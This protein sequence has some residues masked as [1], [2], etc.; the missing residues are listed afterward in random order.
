M[1]LDNTCFESSISPRPTG[2]TIR[3]VP[4]NLTPQY[5]E[6]EQLLRQARSAQDKVT[7]LE[8]MLRIIPKHK[9]TEKLQADLKKRLSKLTKKK[10]LP[11]LEVFIAPF[12]RSIE[13]EPAESS[14]AALPT[15]ES[16]NLWIA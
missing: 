4:A 10:M 12:I 16:R 6:A 5:R 14:C 7:A 13:K 3:I 15:L 8:E 1:D 9:G 2:Y 11:A